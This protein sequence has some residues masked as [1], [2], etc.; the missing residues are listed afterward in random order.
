MERIE[1]EILK[2][3]FGAVSIFF[4]RWLIIGKLRFFTEISSVLKTC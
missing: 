4:N 2:R 3:L 1:G